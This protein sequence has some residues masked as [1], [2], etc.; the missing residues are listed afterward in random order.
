MAKRHRN[1]AFDELENTFQTEYTNYSRQTRKKKKKN[2]MDPVSKVILTVSIIV[3][4]GSGG[5]LLYK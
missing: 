1:D 3:F 4:I 2:K 5:F